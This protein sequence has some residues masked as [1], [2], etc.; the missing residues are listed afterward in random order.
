MT[1][2]DNDSKPTD[3]GDEV[4]TDEPVGDEGAGVEPTASEPTPATWAGRRRQSA[5]EDAGEHDQLPADESEEAPP[6]GDEA[7]DAEAEEAEGDDEAGEPEAEVD[8]V[9]PDDA[10][11]ED[12]EAAAGDTAERLSQDTVEANTLALGDREAAREAALAGLRARAAENASKP[13]TEAI[14]APPPKTPKPTEAQADG[15]QP[16]AQAP[17]APVTPAEETDDEPPPRG[18]WARFAAGS[19]LIIVAMATAT[20]LSGFFFVNGLLD[21]FEGVQPG[22]ENELVVAHP[23]DPQT[24]LILGSDERPE[25]K[26][27]GARSDTT[28]LLRI[29]SNQITVLS[30][31]RDLKVNIP[32]HG[33]D[34]FNAAYTEG[35]P[36]LTVKVVKQLTGITDINHVVNVNF[37]GFADAVNSIGCVYVD[38]DHHYYHSNVGLAA[39][40]QYAEIDIPA[41]YQRMCGYNAL[42]YVRYR[43]DDNDLVRS[44]RQQEFLREMRQELPAERIAN[45]YGDLVDILQ[46]YVTLDIQKGADLINLAKLILSASGAPVV[47]VHFPANLGGPTASYVT[48]SESAIKQAVAKFEGTTP[49]PIPEA[50]SEGSG[51]GSGGGS[52]TGGS[53]GEAPAPPPLI[54]ATATAQETAATLAA[55]KTKGGKPMLRFPVGYPT[56]L[57]PDSIITEDS[58]AFPIDGPGD[59]EYH[60]YKFVVSM[61]TDGYTGY[62][63]VS[64]TDW[65]D[66]PILDNPDET[67]TIDNQEY[68]LSW[69]GGQ[70][71]L[72]GWKTD[73]GSYWVD[74]TL[75]NV[76]T[77]GQMFGIAQSI[78]K[79]TG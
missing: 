9:E 52:G 4:S 72:I 41:G 60:G 30:I 16:P 19:A 32:G 22:I 29:A 3:R 24:I 55:T 5:P 6:A 13:G 53:S 38:V 40:E 25:D 61:P 33:I 79:Y 76:L 69:D 51:S 46:K 12:E 20:A 44:A 35:G 48:A 75:L 47:Q 8:A 2:R 70:L 28:I 58:R 23:G 56:K 15:Q 1:E 7:R 36:K 68:L 10:D 65:K 77:P 49:T 39:A 73:Q 71:R 50:S 78:R 21:G 59:E 54:D 18:I 62:Y 34:K 11:G 63:G 37:T 67:R 26:A 17:P 27:I 74:N 66:P 64:G 45:D 31:P 42:Q 57:A 14:T 43:H